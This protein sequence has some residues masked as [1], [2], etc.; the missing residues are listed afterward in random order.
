VPMIM[1][2]I[3][4]NPKVFG[5][6]WMAATG[7]NEDKMKGSN[8]AVIFGLAFLFSFFLAFGLQF[9]VIHQWH[10]YSILANEPGIRDPNSEVGMMA[11]DFMAKYGTNFRTFKHGA[12]H[13][14]IAGIMIA[15]PI[16][17]TNALFERKGFK[18]VAINV[19]FWMVNMALMGGIICAFS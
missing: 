14:T 10:Y 7:I 1:G 16:I 12:L 2:F 8:M 4:Y 6:A 19:G 9:I 18:Y 15:L 11:K 3:W 13:G 17:G 5:K